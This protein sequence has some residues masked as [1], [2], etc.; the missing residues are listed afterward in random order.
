MCRKE[1]PGLRKGLEGQ[2]QQSPELA[3]WGRWGL[4]TL[5]GG[6]KWWKSSTHSSFEVAP[7]PV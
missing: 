1:A 4:P 6:G 3:S 7:S 5:P 2:T